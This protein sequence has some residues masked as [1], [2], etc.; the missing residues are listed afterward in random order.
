MG[1]GGINLWWWGGK[2]IEGR[3]SRVGDGVDF[4]R[5]GGMSKFSTERKILV[6]DIILVF[7][8]NIEH[9]SNLF[10]R[11]FVA[12]FEQLNTC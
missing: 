9:V 3:E 2:S 8:V 12:D 4:S 7:I 11:A 6:I 1:E 10:S 5:L